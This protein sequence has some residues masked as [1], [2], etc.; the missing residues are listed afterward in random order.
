MI[1]KP[2]E[3]SSESARRDNRKL[4]LKAAR[5]MFVDAGYAAFSMR[6]VAQELGI[7]LGHLQHFFASK[8]DLLSEMLSLT[9]GEYRRNFKKIQ[10]K[11]GF[12]PR[13]Q[14]EDAVDYLVNDVTNKQVSKFFIELWP[15]TGRNPLAFGLLQE[16]FR[17]NLAEFSSFV[18]NAKPDLSDALVESLSIQILALIDGLLIYNHTIRPAAVD[19]ARLKADAVKTIL[20]VIDAA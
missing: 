12:D 10:R 15:I 16:C 4:A 6:S 8:D 14:L 17:E 1:G 2:I 3:P 13:V 19:I 20:A 9:A 11:R 18:R 5:R 7:S